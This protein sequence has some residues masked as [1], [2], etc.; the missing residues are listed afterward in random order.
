LF[1]SGY[2][3]HF[4]LE[5]RNLNFGSR[6]LNRVKKYHLCSIEMKIFS[7]IFNLTHACT[8]VKHLTNNPFDN[9]FNSA[10]GTGTGEKMV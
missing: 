9:G 7:K 3:T 4:Q 6:D 5:W 10:T 1:R 8:V 2:L